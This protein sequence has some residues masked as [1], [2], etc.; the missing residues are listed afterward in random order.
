MSYVVIYMA[1]EK[2]IDLDKDMGWDAIGPFDTLDEAREWGSGYP[3][4]ADWDILPLLDPE[5][6]GV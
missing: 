4:D 2:A 5:D 6:I 3:E 1:G